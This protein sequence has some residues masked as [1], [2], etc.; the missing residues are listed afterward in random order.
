MVLFVSSVNLSTII[1]FFCECLTEFT[2][3]A[4]WPRVFVENYKIIVLYL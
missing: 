4:I 1:L 2:S 3:E